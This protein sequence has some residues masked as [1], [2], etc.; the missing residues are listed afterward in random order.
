MGEGKRVQVLV[1]WTDGSTLSSLNERRDAVELPTGTVTT[2]FSSNKWAHRVGSKIARKEML[3]LQMRS[4][5]SAIR[6][7]LR[8]SMDNE[9]V[10][11]CLE[12][13][14]GQSEMQD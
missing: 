7:R 8:W 14:D 12:C 11:G 1:D 4:L 5:R 6:E 13:L 2:S 10:E 3:F 9:W